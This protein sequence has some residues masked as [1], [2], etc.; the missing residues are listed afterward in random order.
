[1]YY[2]CKLPQDYFLR[3]FLHSEI[4]KPNLQ[5]AKNDFW[6]EMKISTIIANYS[7]PDEGPQLFGSLHFPIMQ[8]LKGQ[9]PLDSQLA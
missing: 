8:L 5:Q 3:G 9:L 6:C 2:D 1:M 4:F 7:H